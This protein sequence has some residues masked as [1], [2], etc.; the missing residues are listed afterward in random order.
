LQQRLDDLGARKEFLTPAEHD[1]L[2]ALV[3]FSEH[4]TI[5][6]LEARLALTRL[7]DAFPNTIDLP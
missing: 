4:R 1:E 3:D 2:S 6:V 7:R 5:E